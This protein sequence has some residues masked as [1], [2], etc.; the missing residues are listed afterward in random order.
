VNFP[1]HYLTETTPLADYGRLVFTP[2]VAETDGAVGDS[3]TID[4]IIFRALTRS[5]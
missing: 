5:R 4:K 2:M 3:L 1:I